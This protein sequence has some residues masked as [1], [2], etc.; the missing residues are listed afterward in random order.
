MGRNIAREKVRGCWVLFL[1]GDEEL[2]E[3]YHQL[4]YPAVF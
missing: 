4:G 2:G 3:D 1:D